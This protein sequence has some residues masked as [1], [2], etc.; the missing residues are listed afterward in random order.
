MKNS[1]PTIAIIGACL[2]IVSGC[3]S[4][5]NVLTKTDKARNVA[6][7]TVAVATTEVRRTTLQPATVHAFYRAE[8]RA[9]VSGYVKILHADIGDY[10]AAGANLATIDVPEMLEQRHVIEKKIA[11]AHAQEERARADVQLAEAR[12]RSAKALLQEASSQMAGAEASLAGS[13]AEFDRTQDL[14]QRGSLQ[15]R[16][17]DE[18]RMKRDSESARKDAMTS[19]IESAKAGVGVAEAQVASSQAELQ[20]T[21]AE[22]G[23]AEAQLEE[24]KVLMSFATLKSPFAGMVTQR[25]VEPGDLVRQSSEVG[26]GKPLFVIS[27]IDKVRVRIPV[28][29]SDAPLVSIGDEVALTFPSFSSEPPLVGTVTRRSGSLDPSTRTMQVEVELKNNDGKLLPGMFGQASITLA[30]KVAANMLPAQA[31]RFDEEGK[32]FVYIVCD[33]D[34]IER[35]DVTIGSDNGISIEV[36]SGVQPGQRVLD[37]NLNRFIDG[38]KVAVL[39]AR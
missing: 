28:P 9:K 12:V 8:V 16:M 35:A 1:L 18:A 11:R 23:I 21:Q 27:Q 32:G 26:N 19:S 36:L 13:Q 6:V 4:N 31:I 24:M 5:Q 37:A 38:Q 2:L 14:V 29:E 25:S 30:T 15:N 3:T 17:L 10:V 33:D 39:E 7:K 20:A 34:T 22:T